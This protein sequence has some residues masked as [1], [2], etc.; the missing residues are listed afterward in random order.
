MYLIGSALE[1]QTIVMPT[2]SLL[3]ASEAII[4]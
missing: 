2:Q 4:I 3:S 1:R